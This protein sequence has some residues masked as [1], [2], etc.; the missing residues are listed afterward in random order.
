MLRS[1]HCIE[2]LLS[3]FGQL[4]QQGIT[5]NFEP[6]AAAGK[7][8]PDLP[9]YPWDHAAS[10]WYESRVSK[11][12]RF[13]A[14]GQHAILG[15]R[16]PESTSLDP[17]W[18][19]MLSLEDEPW[20]AD[21]KVKDDIV[22]PFA[23]Y[24]AMAG[25]AVRQIS[26]IEA[27]YSV[28][29][30]V[31]HTALVLT[32]SKPQEVVTTLRRHK[33][34]DSTDSDYYD[35]VISSYSGS[36]WIKNCEGRVKANEAVIPSPSD[37]EE[38]PHKVSATRWYEIMARVG[39]VYGPE[40][41]GISA[42]SSS[43][44]EQ[45]AVGDITLSK[46]QE[47]AP[48][49]FHPAAIDSCLQL[50][51]AAMAKGAGR[52]FTQLYVPTMVEE[53]DISRSALQMK[54]KAWYLQ[55]GKEIGIDCVADG[56]T[57]LRLRGIRM[58][59][60][61]D[62]RATAAADR[63]AAARLEWCPDFDF[64]DVA[65]LF[66]AP[67]SS[68]DEKQLLEELALLCIL[69][70]AE[71]LEG[72]TTEEPHF[73]K[74]RDWLRREVHR[75]E[76]GTYPV[77]KDSPSYFK[78]PRPARLAQIKALYEK[79]CV[80]SKG[81]VAAGI[82][83]ICEN[84]EGLFT[85]KVDTLELLMEGDVLTEIYNAV[86]FGYGD[87]VRMLS[88]TKPNLRILEVGAGT[89]GTTE[90]ILRDLVSSGGNPAYSLYTYTDISAGFFAAAK[91]RFAYAPNMDFK[92][93]DITQ[94]FKEQGFEAGSYDL[95]LAPNVIH[96]TPSLQETLTN[97]QPLLRP[98][99]HLVLSEVCAVARAPGYVFG[100]FS[101]W[102]LGEA[103]DRLW[104]PYISVERWDRELKQAG[105]TGVDT[106]AYDAEE[107]Y[108]Y[109]ATIV[110]R[111][112]SDKM[113]ANERSITLLCDRPEEGI[114]R[115]LVHDLKQAGFAISIA[116]LGEPLPP[117]QDIIATLD[118]ESHFFENISK[119]RFLALQELLRHHKS[120]KLLWLM[121][122]TQVHC[123]DPRSAQTIGMIRTIRAELAL[124]FHTLEIEPA[125]V[126]FSNLLLKVFEKVRT[127]DDIDNLA[128]DR[129]FAVDNGIIKLGRYQPFPLEQ[130]VCEKSITTSG[131]VKT[132][133]IGKP[134][135]L[136]TLQWTEGSLPSGLQDN[137]VEIETRAV[138]LN[139]RVSVDIFIDTSELKLTAKGYYVL[140]GSSLLRVEDCTSRCGAIRRR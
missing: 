51:V 94:N 85:G 127:R 31:A 105:Y 48:F 84:A 77:V 118:L 37:M 52:H 100:N 59:P 70:S 16:V 132:L 38:L 106:A 41:Q 45:I 4:Y 99:G 136:E 139:F 33:L 39:L 40:F 76:I 123:V 65:P 61:D 86:S 115:R 34:T 140:H 87:F 109:C 3:A 42:L 44:T 54:A 12:W 125:E 10:Y 66:K 81:L 26:G 57:V 135:L 110:T 108:R 56:R 133:E 6:M 126:D 80:K 22:F 116:K 28:R 17:C 97:L 96:A 60:L 103:D 32:D 119:E 25:E 124:P 82:M 14:F 79:L 91:E 20:L 29:H 23:G 49:V 5:L 53:L 24:V 89:G 69:D 78:L 131:H 121:P 64:M 58:N 2:S 1:N 88:N 113:E 13:R 92:V 63:H 9:T 62:D 73:L 114:S 95:I 101:G 71:R 68:N 72:L 104:E 107:P 30:V 120:Q 74:F 36:M 130:E 47:K 134:G 112:K 93:F 27:G 83:R 128:P 8:L 21:H 19:V 122:Q 138:G 7:V 67:L 55:D 98:H 102:W 11:D 90:L 50:A 111:P 129:E 15:Q 117:T 18:R 137:E 75:A 46:N 43:A 35:F